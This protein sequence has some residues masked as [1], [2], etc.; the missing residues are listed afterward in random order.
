MLKG[1]FG[2]EGKDHLNAKAGYSLILLAKVYPLLANKGEKV[3]LYTT[4]NNL[5]LK[6]KY[7]L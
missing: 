4:K 7:N 6:E 3:K 5:N 1:K 2:P